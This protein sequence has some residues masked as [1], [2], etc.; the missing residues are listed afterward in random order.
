MFTL[1][2]GVADADTYPVKTESFLSIYLDEKDFPGALSIPRAIETPLT[3]T[4]IRG[5]TGHVYG[6]ALGN[7]CTEEYRIPDYF[8]VAGTGAEAFRAAAQSN[9]SHRD[10]SWSWSRSWSPRFE[11]LAYYRHIRKPYD[12]R[13]V[14]PRAFR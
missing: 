3:Q 12:L 10:W 11:P 2:R 8:L 4:A 9:F 13:P 14:Q 1:K 5:R 7:H 6:D